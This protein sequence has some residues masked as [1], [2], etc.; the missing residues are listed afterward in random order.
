ME[1]LFNG[2]VRV[3]F[4]NGAA[5]T[6]GALVKNRLAPDRES[7]TH[8]PQ[9]KSAGPWLQSRCYPQKQ[10]DIAIYAC[11]ATYMQ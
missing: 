8:T 9:A 3:R 7:Q 11:E 5:P 10:R 6:L 1:D 4:P 2:A